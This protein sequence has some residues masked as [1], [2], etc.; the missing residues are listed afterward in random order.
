[1][2]EQNP[3]RRLRVAH[4]IVQPVLV[5]DDGEEMEPGPAVQPSTLPVSKV[6]EALASLPAQLAQMEQA[7]LGETA[8]PTE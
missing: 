6:A 3:T 7:E 5:W 8:A 2:T 1:M 4:V